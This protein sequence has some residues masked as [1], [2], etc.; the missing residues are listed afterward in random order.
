MPEV[1]LQASWLKPDGHRLEAARFG[2][3]DA[4]P[5]A[6]P[7]FEKRSARRRPWVTGARMIF[8]IS[9]VLLGTMLILTIVTFNNGT[10]PSP[11]PPS[12]RAP[13]SA[14]LLPP[15]PPDAP[16]PPPPLPY[17]PNAGVV[18]KT[19]TCIREIAGIKISF[20]HNSRCEDGGPGSTAALCAIGSDYPD[21]PVRVVFKR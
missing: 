18:M 12:P 8:A 2:E 4:Q 14:P 17:A 16:P 11:P 5:F 7:V 20:A 9:T 6:K 1:V 13:P 19:S 21:C 15:S 3:F 10:T